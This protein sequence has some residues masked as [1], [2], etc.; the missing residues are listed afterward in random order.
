MLGS[1]DHPVR[2]LRLALINPRPK[3][4]QRNSISIL[5]TFVQR[6]LEARP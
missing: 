2:A 5:A 1:Y 4:M 6:Q 3:V